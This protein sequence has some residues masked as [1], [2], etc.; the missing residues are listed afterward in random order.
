VADTPELDSVLDNRDQLQF[1]L[2]SQWG[3]IAKS[4]GSHKGRRFNLGALLRCC[5]KRE[6]RGGVVTLWLGYLSHRERLAEELSDPETRGM[7]KGAL[8][9]V[10]GRP[11][12][13]N[14]SGDNYPAAVD[15]SPELGITPWQ[16]RPQ[17]IAR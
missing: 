5:T 15:K 10:L 12:E 1:K 13:I 4:L 14:V 9:L 17:G 8:G 7:L 3:T 11:H 6:A 2:D 16:E